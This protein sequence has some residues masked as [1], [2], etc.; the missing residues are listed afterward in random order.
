MNI[1][2]NKFIYLF[3]CKN[4]HEIIL[5]FFIIMFSLV[6]KNKSENVCSSKKIE[7]PST[8]TAT[9][10]HPVKENVSKDLNE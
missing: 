4:I 10:T 6:L 3:T 2:V 5:L 7:T 9:C 1:C 8:K